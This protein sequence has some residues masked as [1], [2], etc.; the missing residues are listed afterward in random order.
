MPASLA[1]VPDAAVGDLEVDRLLEEIGGCAE[2]D[3]S[4]A[5]LVK[6]YNNA[7]FVLPAAEVVVRV[8]GS[9]A[10]SGKLDKVVW[11]ARW[12][13]EIGFPAVRLAQGKPNP[14]VTA[15]AA[16]SIWDLVRPVRP[17][18]PA[19]L[20][21]LLRQLHGCTPP[22]ELT[23]W[24]PVEDVRVRVTAADQLSRE[25][26]AFL[27]RVCDDLET[28]LDEL[29]DYV[30]CGVI[31]GDACLDNV[32][33][34]ADGPVLCDLD[35]I[36]RG[37]LD[38]DLVPMRTASYHFEGGERDH[39]AFLSAYRPSNVGARRTAVLHRLR[40]LKL[41]TSVVSLLQNN[42]SVRAEFK[43]RLRTFRAGEHQARWHRFADMQ[44]A[45]VQE[46]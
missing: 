4:G 30:E 9:A 24:T 25:D 27:L 14:V 18:E 20:A 22:A 32:I 7:T 8:A 29:D 13:E 39:A 42:P 11:A 10:L 5:Q 15:N 36:S 40:E 21:G 2:L 35:R 1:R 43:H 16:A 6:Y 23:V 28:D 12:L 33:V 37:P 46:G 45:K 19:D 26:R 31:H 41:V 3:T 44:T 38:W 34:G 17:P